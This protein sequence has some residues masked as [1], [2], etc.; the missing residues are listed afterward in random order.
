MLSR[1]QMHP[2]TL[3]IGLAITLLSANGCGAQTD[4]DVFASLAREQSL[5]ESYV[6]MLN[7][8]GV[9]DRRVY[10]QGIR[11]YARAKAE[12]DS[13]I[14]KLKH[15]I[16]QG[17]DVSE[18]EEYQAILETAVDARIAFTTHID[19]EVIG[20]DD[21]KRSGVKAVITTVVELLP[22]LAEASVAIWEAYRDATT[23]RRKEILARL[24]ALKWN[25][26]RMPDN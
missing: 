11:L 18:S 15:E 2:F 17:D 22:A 6:D 24:D 9:E 8:F 12:F 1:F 7:Q 21:G 23:D 26:F 20:D 3:A 10:A 4:N 5:A 19:K 16:S 25:P 13:F 14:E